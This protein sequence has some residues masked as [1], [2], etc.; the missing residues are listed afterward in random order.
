MTAPVVGRD[1]LDVN[2]HSIDDVAAYF[3]EAKSLIGLHRHAGA[4]AVFE[5]TVEYEY[6]SAE[7]EYDGVGEPEPCRAT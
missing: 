4:D 2:Q 7:Y 3:A 1:R 6:R 5:K